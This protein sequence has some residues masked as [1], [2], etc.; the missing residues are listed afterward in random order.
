MITPHLEAA[1]R[2]HLGLSETCRPTADNALRGDALLLVSSWERR[3]TEICGA[4][5][6]LFETS[7]VVRFLETGVSGRRAKHDATLIGHARDKA[8]H[9]AELVS[10]SVRDFFGW[11][12]VI[13]DYIIETMN[14]VQRPIDLVV[15]M[16]CLPKYY[17]L[18]Y[19]P[20]ITY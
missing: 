18:L 11:R 2:G 20:N 8:A 9:Y 4:Q 14:R 6:G 7:A 10:L 16:T 12:D 13:A 19:K 5:I 1:R 15:D 17:L 3:C